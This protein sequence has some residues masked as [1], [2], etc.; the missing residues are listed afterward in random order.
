MFRSTLTLPVAF[1]IV[2]MPVQFALADGFEAVGGVK[3][4]P[5]STSLGQLFGKFTDLRSLSGNPDDDDTDGDDSGD[6]NGKTGGGSSGGDD[7]DKTGG[8]SS[9]GDGGSSGGGAGSGGGA[10]NGDGGQACNNVCVCPLKFATAEQC[11][12]DQQLNRELVPDLPGKIFP[13]TFHPP[14]MN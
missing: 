5:Y 9:G 4:L 11:Q 13:P 2:V 1:A 12:L 10:T 6:D 7:N 3:L 14:Q 8:D